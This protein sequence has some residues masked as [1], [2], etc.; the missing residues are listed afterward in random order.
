MKRE[1]EIESRVREKIP[2]MSEQ[3]HLN[4]DERTNNQ[5]SAASVPRV[6]L[7]L[8]RLY[9]HTQLFSITPAF[10]LNEYQYTLRTTR[11]HSRFLQ[12]SDERALCVLAKCQS[13]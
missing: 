2:E 5:F 3:N 7:V 8:L 13:S 10:K 1:R 9:F 4:Q 6:I 11:S 12:L